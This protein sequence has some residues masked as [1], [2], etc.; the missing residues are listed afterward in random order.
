MN[1]KTYI[2]LSPKYDKAQVCIWGNAKDAVRIFF[3]N[4][5]ECPGGDEAT[6]EEFG[7][8]E[9]YYKSPNKHLIFLNTVKNFYERIS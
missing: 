1:Y 5:F 3:S 2:F 8:W 6:L 7:D 9:V 4:N